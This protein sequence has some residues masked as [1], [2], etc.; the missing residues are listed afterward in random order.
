MSQVVIIYLLAMVSGVNLN[1]N[2]LNIVGVIVMVIMGASFFATLSLVIACLVKT[3]ERFMGIGQLI[4]MPLFF[5]SN[6]IYPIDIMPTWLKI[7]A[8]GNPL[9][10]EVDA[11]RGLMLSGAATSNAFVVNFGIML[12]ATIIIVYIGSRLY[13]NVVT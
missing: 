12:L 2:P 7:V 13:P 4:T 1:W 9:T 6:A 10:Y 3:R 8:R 5:A 11:L